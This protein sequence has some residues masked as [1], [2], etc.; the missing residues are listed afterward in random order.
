MTPLFLIHSEQDTACA[1]Q[2][3]HDLAARG[4]TIWEDTSGAAPDST[5]AL[6]AWQQGIKDSRV[7]IVVWSTAAAQAASVAQRLDYAHRLYKHTLVV[8]IDTTAR[9]DA[10]ANARTISSTPPCADAAAQLREHLPLMDSDHLLQDLLTSTPTGGTPGQPAA[11]SSEAAHIFGVRCSKGHV[12]YFDKREV[13][14]EDGS[15]TRSIVYRDNRPLDALRLR[16]GTAGC[17][18]WVWVD[19]DCEGYK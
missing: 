18:E 13:C 12:T 2:I 11:A 15:I 10:L 4:Y 6:R 3:R 17:G 9:P 8:A 19:V 14:R 16:C 1:A 7:V 5:A